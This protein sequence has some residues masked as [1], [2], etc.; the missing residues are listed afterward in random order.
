MDTD[1]RLAYT[2]AVREFM[3]TYSTKYCPRTYGAVGVEEVKD[4]A[5]ERIIN[6]CKSN[7]RVK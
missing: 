5:I 3:D 4:C 7:N 2:S 1:F 6:I